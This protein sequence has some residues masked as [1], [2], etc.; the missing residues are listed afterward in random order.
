MLPDSMCSIT[1]IRKALDIYE[2]RALDP[3]YT[4]TPASVLIP[5]VRH[6]GGCDIVFVK[7]REDISVHPGE[8][9]FPGG[10]VEPSDANHAAAALRETFEEISHPVDNIEILGEIDPTWTISEYVIHCYVGLLHPPFD[11][12]PQESE[13]TAVVRL[14]LKELLE[15]R[16]WNLV[17]IEIPKGLPPVDVHEVIVNG[18]RIWGAT[19]RILRTFFKAAFGTDPAP[20]KY[21]T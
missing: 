7:R 20:K 19:A 8:Y 3:R 17:P 10:H 15:P 14:P 5:L 2:P 18:H 12:V 9:S 11:F 16:R 13:L 21:E 6:N 1:A 4:G